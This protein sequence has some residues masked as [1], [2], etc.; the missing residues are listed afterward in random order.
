MDAG[1]IDTLRRA[2]VTGVLALAATM[3][4][5]APAHAANPEPAL[6][7]SLRQWTGGTGT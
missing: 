6:V 7:P 1:R 5:A 4:T 3:L 2:A